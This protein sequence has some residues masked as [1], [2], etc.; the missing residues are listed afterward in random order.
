MAEY[1][2]KQ[3]K[4]YCR[5]LK[6]FSSDEPE[7]ANLVT[8]DEKWDFTERVKKIEHSIMEKL[9]EFIGEM[10][11]D[12]VEDEEN[13]RITIKIDVLD[14]QTFEK[15]QQFLDSETYIESP[16]KKHKRHTS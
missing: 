13:D 7:D 1:L 11:P 5:K 15:V 9:A 4:R 12:A 14:R 16:H 8:F 10:C 3:T 6:I 2:E